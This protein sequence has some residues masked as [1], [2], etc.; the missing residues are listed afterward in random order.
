MIRSREGK[1]IL[2]GEDNRAAAFELSLKG[3]VLIKSGKKRKEKEIW[4][5]ER[6]KDTEVEKGYLG[7]EKREEKGRDE[8]ACI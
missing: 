7:E 4:V 8:E 1:L 5:E 2:P 6:V 3:W